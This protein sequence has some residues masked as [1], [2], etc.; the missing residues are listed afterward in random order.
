MA[1]ARQRE[2]D[3][4]RD[5]AA[6]LGR[7]A[8]EAANDGYYFNNAGEKVDWRRLVDVAC[9]AKRSI[10]P[11]AP[12]PASDR[13]SVAETRVQV[14]NETTL[15]TSL[16]LTEGGQR[17][18]ALNFANGIHPG[19]GFRS[20]A[21]AQEEVLC[22]SSA[23]Y[24]T[25]VD[26]PM[27]EAH[28]KR[29]RPDSTDW[30]I[31]SPDVPVF[32]K[33]EGTELDRPWLLSF[34]TCAAPVAS[35]IGQSES[36]DL[37]QKRIHRVL[38]IAQA[39]RY[40]T[41]VLGAW[42]CG[43]FGNDPRRTAVDF[44][45]ALENEFRGHFPTLSSPSRTGRRRE[46]FSD[47]S[48]MFS[49]RRSSAVHEENFE[50]LGFW[51]QFRQ[52]L[53]EHKIQIRLGKPPK[54]SS[55]NVVLR[56]SH[57]R[58]R[59]WRL[60]R[61]NRLGVSVQFNDPDAIARWESMAQDYRAE[62]DERLAP[63]GV[64]EWKP[65]RIVL[66][67]G[68]TAGKAESWQERNAWLANAIETV[69]TVFNE[70]LP[71][72]PQLNLKFKDG[73]VVNSDTG[74][75]YDVLSIAAHL[76]WAAQKTGNSSWEDYPPYMPKHEFVV[77]GKC[78]YADWDVLYFAC[79]KHPA[80]YLAYFR[81]YPSAMR[82]WEPGDGYRYWPTALRGVLMIN[83]CTLD[84]VEPPRRKDQGGRPIKPKDWGAPPWLPQANGWPPSYLKKHPDL[85]REIGAP[86]ITPEEKE[87]ISGQH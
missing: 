66:S 58:L 46:D 55:S 80:I 59:P 71:P 14:S 29:S 12:L 45:E 38:A 31:Y 51:T 20:G 85:A 67:R 35:R 10:P 22:R 79:T 81:G 44:R 75:E 33:D 69:L 63:C 72:S 23:L 21:R 86:V 6:A 42:G 61:D 27:Y 8:V 16:R 52:Y 24:R 57:F 28:R 77:F 17:P 70:I 82:Y 30:A 36:G 53:D 39:F 84:S 74:E 9:S 25:L 4:P 83:R 34:I 64:L 48:G 60:L 11:D 78:N 19:G 43:A 76:P 3:I 54:S 32:R 62:I 5:I 18:L 1:A 15:G 49:L 37:L 13:A 47:L 26:D 2:L 65:G 41:L 56:R 7:S 73:R 68:L 50:H 40:S 87:R